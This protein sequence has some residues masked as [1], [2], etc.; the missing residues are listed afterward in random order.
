MEEPA[1]NIGA[2]CETTRLRQLAYITAK[3]GKSGRLYDRP[4]I[5]QH[6][7]RDHSRMRH[8]EL[9]R[10][11]PATR[12]AEKDRGPDGKRS[13]YG[14]EVAKFDEKIVILRRGVVFG[15]PASTQ[16]DGKYPPSPAFCQGRCQIVEIGCGA[17]EPRQ[18]D[19]RKCGR[20]A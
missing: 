4:N 10:Q 13:Q 2:F 14:H 5:V 3:A 11:Q 12:T 9:H 15:L 20:H 17:G 18:A 8:A 7:A 6:H 16:V 19:H 1:E